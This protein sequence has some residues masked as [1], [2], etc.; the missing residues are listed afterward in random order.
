MN[1][2]R[3]APPSLLDRAWLA[4]R[5]PYDILR[6]P[7]DALLA[8]PGLPILLIPTFSSYTTSLNLL[9][10]YLTWSTLIVSNPPLRVELLGTLGIRVFFYLLPSF[11]FLAFDSALPNLA[12]GMKE[13]GDIALPLGEEQGSKKGRW[14]RVALVSTFNVLLGVVL[15]SGFELL[16][17]RVLHVRSALKL[18]TSL[19]MPW[20]VAIDLV[21]GFLLR[22]G[23]TYLLHRYALH[24]PDS[25]VTPYHVSWQH[26][27]VAPYSLISHYDHPLPYVLRVFLPTYLPALLCRFHLLTYLLYLILVSLE[28]AFAYSGYNVLPT[29]LILGGIARRQE[30]HL[31]GEGKGNFGCFGIAD[32]VCG[33][34]VGDE[35]VVDDVRGEAEWKQVGE[36]AK[37]KARGV[38]RKTKTRARE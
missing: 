16:F 35:D 20:A 31:M 29:G 22:E 1:Y 19:P 12:T 8:I 37:A 36:R 14:W 13:H 3:S 23:F 34:G 17:T 9:F 5:Y 33:T 15:Q 28:E 32:F 7:F 25:P 10:F 38:G 18:S 27:I 26:S 11:G 2:F 21:R 30:K 6:H 24:H 4:L